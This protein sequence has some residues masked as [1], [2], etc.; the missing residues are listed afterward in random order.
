MYVPLL[1]L[2]GISRYKAQKNQQWTEGFYTA[3]VSSFAN[4]SIMFSTEMIRSSM[5]F[6]YVGVEEDESEQIRKALHYQGTHLSDYKPEAQKIFDMSAQKAPVA[7]SLTRFYVRQN[8]KMSTEYRVF[9]R[10]TEG[11]ARNIAF[12]RETLDKVNTLYSHEMGEHFGQVVKES[13]WKPN[14]QGVLINA[15]FFNLSW[16]RT[17]NP[18]AT[19]P[20]QFRVSAAKE[21]LIPMMHE[22]SKFAFGTLGHLKATAVLVP[23]SQGDLQMLLIKPDQPDGLAH[24]QGK[25]TGMDIVSVARNL[26]MMDVFV[27]L[28][29]F[30]LHSHLELTSALEKLGIKDIFKPSKSFS[31]L[32]HRNTNFRIDGVI[33]VVTFEFQEQGIGMPSTDVGNGSLTHTFNGVKYFLATHPFAFYIIDRT[34][35]FFAG[36]VTSF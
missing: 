22:D 12:N 8:L 7:K 19:Y 32:L 24:L 1:I 26:T 21:V 4:R 5:L 29:K 25:L 27:G 28:P 31:T 20:R 18:E 23:F 14:S 30:R 2:L 33:H 9:M 35:I 17:F 36:H 11:R 6:I 34:T 3:I 16:E 10:H 15:I 13:W